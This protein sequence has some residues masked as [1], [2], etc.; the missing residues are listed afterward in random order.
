[1]QQEFKNLVPLRVSAKHAL[2]QEQ[3]GAVRLAADTGG[4]AVRSTTSS[5]ASAMMASRL[6]TIC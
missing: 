4:Q 3:M 5:L 6:R 2:V 1:L